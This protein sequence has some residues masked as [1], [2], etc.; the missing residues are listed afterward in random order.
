MG[1][2]KKKNLTKIEEV[3]GTLLEQEPLGKEAP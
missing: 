3:E 1:G 2:N